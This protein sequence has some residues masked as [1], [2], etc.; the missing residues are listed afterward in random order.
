MLSGIERANKQTRILNSLLWSKNVSLN[1][2]ERIFSA[3][4]EIILSYLCEIWIVY[5]GLYKKLLSTKMEFLELE[6]H[7]VF[8]RRGM[9]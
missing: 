4:A 8:Y 6:K 7:S 9:N 5:Y 3:V 1:T 2:K